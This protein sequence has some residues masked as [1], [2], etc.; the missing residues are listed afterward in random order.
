MTGLREAEPQHRAR[1]APSS[2]NGGVGSYVK[3]DDGTRIY[4]ECFSPGAGSARRLVRYSK[5]VPPVLLLMGFAANGRLWAPAVTRLLAAGHH[6]ITVDHRG[7]GR[8]STPWRP[9][10]TR[11]M[12]RDV[13]AVMD[14]LGIEQAHVSGG[15]LG[16][17]VAQE[18]ALEFPDRVSK[19]ILASTTGGFRRLDTASATGLPHVFQALF[20]SLHPASDPDQR[21]RDFLCTAASEDFA[22]E[23]GPGDEAWDTIAAMFEDPNSR[24]GLALQL[25]AAARH[26]A[27]S[28]LPRLDM[29]VRVHHGS[30]DLLI[31]LAAGRELARRIPRARFEIHVGAGHALFE[32]TEEVSEAVLAFLGERNASASASHSDRAPAVGREDGDR[33]RRRP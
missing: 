3:A 27:W 4:L 5:D 26:S 20:R 7:C 23:C 32:R 14:E 1:D 30:E 24:R 12:A 29:P 9:W 16:G 18:L 25:L 17:M 33:T 13:V 21:V 19:L 31:P 22:A 8:S 15:S 11:T 10:T 6:V 28:R 2:E